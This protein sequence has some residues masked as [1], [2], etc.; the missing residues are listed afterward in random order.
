MM[1]WCKYV[2]R[3]KWTHLLFR[4]VT[5]EVDTYTGVN[6]NGTAFRFVKDRSSFVHFYLLILVQELKMRSGDPGFHSRVG[7]KCYWVFPSGI[8]Q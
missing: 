4:S 2:S 6:I 8:S 1:A 5:F 7:Q 3:C